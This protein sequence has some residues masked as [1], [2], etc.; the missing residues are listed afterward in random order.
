MKKIILSTLFILTSLLSFGQFS[1][2]ERE[3]IE[4]EKKQDS[5]P[6]SV[7]LDTTDIKNLKLVYSGNTRQVWR[8]TNKETQNIEQFYDV[9]LKFDSKEKA[10]TFHKEYWKE[11][12][13]YGPEV[14]NHKIKVN[15]T[16]D[17]RVFKG[18]D[19]VNQMVAQYGLQM[20][21]FIFVVDNY[22]VKFY[23]SCKKELEPSIIQPYLDSVIK[24]VK[25]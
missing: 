7:F 9:R 22:Y 14:K 12:S 2:R 25:H 21:C 20:Y 16:E 18:S 1:E 24:K 19:M 13:E 6:K 10:L 11:N 3:L 5:I 4:F 15:G 8:S 17:F 23:I